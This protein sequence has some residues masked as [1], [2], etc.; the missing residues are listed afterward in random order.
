MNPSPAHNAP[1]GDWTGLPP[2]V[3]RSSSLRLP[4][5]ARGGVKHRRLRLPLRLGGAGRLVLVPAVAV[6]LLVGA[7]QASAATL[8]VCQN[9]CPYTQ[10]A[11][12][13]AA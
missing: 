6:L 1:L 10:L 11:P 5:P 4:R 3:S 13:L 12:A 8:N 7:R 2:V 9:G